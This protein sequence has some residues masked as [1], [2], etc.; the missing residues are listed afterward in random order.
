MSIIKTMPEASLL[1]RGSKQLV[2]D[3]FVLSQTSDESDDLGESSRDTKPKE[4]P[5]DQ[6]EVGTNSA[7][8]PSLNR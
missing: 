7:N 4:K 1:Q 3:V 2:N 6:P 5:R 8:P